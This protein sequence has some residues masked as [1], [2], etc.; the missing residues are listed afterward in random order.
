MKKDR[1]HSTSRSLGIIHALAEMMAG[2]MSQD[3]V[4]QALYRLADHYAVPPTDPAVR[5]WN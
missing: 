4:A 2:E 3:D 1:D 5:P